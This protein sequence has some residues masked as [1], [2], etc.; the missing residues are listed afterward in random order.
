MKKAIIITVLV[1]VAI[2]SAKYLHRSTYTEHQFG[3]HHY[4]VYFSIR[5]AVFSMAVLLIGYQLKAKKDG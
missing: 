1:I 4:Q 3:Y 2:V 5:L